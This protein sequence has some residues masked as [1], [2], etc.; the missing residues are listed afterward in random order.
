MSLKTR[1]VVV[2]RDQPS[3]VAID[4]GAS[5]LRRGG[6][7]AFATETVYGLGADATDP[8]AVTRIFAAK[9]RPDVNPLIVHADGPDMARS[10]VASWPE[11]ARVLAE[12][13][14]PGP[15]TLVLPRSA[16]IPDVV[17]AG[18]ETVGVRVP[19]TRVARSLIAR[20]GRPVA[21]PSANRSTGISPTMARHVLKDLD[22]QIDLIFDS[23]PT[24]L[25][26]ESTVLDLSRDSPRLLRPGPIS[27]E[28][29]SETLGKDV[30]G[31]D[32]GEP[33]GSLLSPGQMAIHY[34]PR[35][36]T[37]RIDPG[38]MQAFP[39]PAQ[40]ALIVVGREWSREGVRAPLTF[41]LPTPEIAAAG[42]YATLH[43]CDE[44]G[45][46]LIVIVPPPSLPRW[47]AIL[48]RLGRASVPFDS[49][50]ASRDES[51]R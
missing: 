32:P 23:G 25:G 30:E 8:A 21:A 40:S 50:L 16:R 33:C 48:D 41:D 28:F 6:L 24:A 7:V 11:E 13:C 17:T 15:L 9:G 2:D 22:G 3:R 35:T 49:W 36:S 43:H 27:R 20:A 18:R 42:L 37:V 4:D 14:W 5:V 44:S 38:L 12:A 45:V 10:C 1:T 29:L 46:E 51:T 26:L 39:W 34:A 31:P 47:S 19:D